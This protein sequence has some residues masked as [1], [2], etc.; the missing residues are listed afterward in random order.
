M[1]AIAQRIFWIGTISWIAFGFW[2]KVSGILAYAGA[3]GPGAIMTWGEMAVEAAV[4]ALAI[5]WPLARL[6]QLAVLLTLSAF[7]AVHV[8][9][10]FGIIRQCGCFGHLVM[11]EWAMLALNAGLLIIATIVRKSTQ[12]PS[13]PR[14]TICCIHPF[15][16]TVALL[17]TREGYRVVEPAAATIGSSSFHVGEQMALIAP[18]SPALR[19][20]AGQA[21]AGNETVDILL[22]DPSCQAC[23]RVLPMFTDRASTESMRAHHQWEFVNIGDGEDP[24]LTY[25]RQFALY[26]HVPDRTIIPPIHVRIQRGVVNEA[27]TS[28]S[29]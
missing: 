24:Q 26:A 4:L 15:M 2:M 17:L 5:G 18:S 20:I 16:M 7:T 19:W 8:L 23:R 10:L 11:P 29:E 25:L 27:D 13:I 21:S 1:A 28:D 14:W 9:T 12:A 6:T 3:G 22:Y